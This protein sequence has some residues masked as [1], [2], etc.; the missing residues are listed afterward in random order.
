[1]NH[2][3]NKIKKLEM[4]IEKM[5]KQIK[6]QK[7]SVNK[8][9]IMTYG[10]KSGLTIISAIF[11]MLLAISSNFIGDTLTCKTKRILNENIY[12]KFFIIFCVIYFA[13]SLS[14]QA[15]SD[16]V[17]PFFIGLS[18]IAILLF[19]IIFIKCNIYFIIITVIILFILL[20]LTNYQYYYNK[21]TFDSIKERKH[22]INQIGVV[23]RT[24]LSIVVVILLIGFIIYF[25]N[26][27]RCNKSIQSFIFN[28]TDCN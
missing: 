1:M 16:A 11:L 18:S 17:H 23:Y 5:E 9:G 28:K 8:G 2:L 4:N 19:Y 7:N 27:Y 12:V 21:T 20:I 25:K 22:K 24:L 26:Q 13:M 14:A 15:N 6:L 10:E 3:E